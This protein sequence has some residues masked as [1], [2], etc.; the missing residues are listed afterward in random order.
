MFEIKNKKVLNKQT[1]LMDIYAPLIAE[2]CR[3]GQFIIFR[4]DE[5]G[6]RVPLTICDADQ[7]EGTIRIVFQTIG[8]STTQL[9]NLNQGDFILDVVG[10]LGHPTDLN[11]YQKVCIVVG[12]LGSAIGFM[13]AKQ[14]YGT[15]T[16]VD[17]VA[18]FRTKDLVI[19]ED[20][21]RA[22]SNNFYLCT[23]D[24]SAGSQGFVTDT[25]KN[26]CQKNT[27][28]L[29]LTM[30]PLSMMK[31]VAKV[32]EPYHIKTIASMNP[33]M[34][35][36]SGMCGGCRL[37]VGG[38]MRFACVDGPDFDAHEVDFDELIIRNQFYREHETEAHE[39]YCRLTKEIRSHE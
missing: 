2:R 7:A 27:Y 30:G 23:D 12:G 34:I 35:D 4:I 21:M 18:G 39:H 16:Q 6:E 33:I 17:I 14:L 37:S 32:T 29:V 10:P 1:V 31:F 28:D 3:A 26:L 5:L 19:L 13:S 36:G 22:Y 20:E 25:L 11:S 24:G 15:G 38:E 9:G 8:K